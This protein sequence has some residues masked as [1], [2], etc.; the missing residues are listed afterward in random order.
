MGRDWVQIVQPLETA[1]QQMGIVFETAFTPESF[2]I[3]FEFRIQNGHIGRSQVRIHQVLPAG[4]ELLGEWEHAGIV[5]DN[6]DNT[7]FVSADLSTVLEEAPYEVPWADV[8]QMVW[9]F[10][11]ASYK[12]A[13]WTTRPE[14]KDRPLQPYG[15]G[16]AAAIARQIDQAKSVGIDGFIVSWRGPGSRSEQ[17]FP[18]ILQVAG[19][20]DFAI[21]VRLE[22]LTDA[23]Q[24]STPPE[25]AQRLIRLLQNHGRHSAFLDGDGRP[26]VFVADSTATPAATW[27]GIFNLVRTQGLDGFFLA[28]STN[29]SDADV[30]DALYTYTAT[31]AEEL[32]TLVAGVWG[33]PRYRH[34][35]SD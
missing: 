30:F 31:S 4:Q 19:Q 17:N 33:R 34:L 25:I 22:T 27:T 29:H 7:V 10:Y 23:G 8:P 11:E 15:S 24:P 18:A 21:S 26:V 16:V 1:G 12:Q 13:D 5:D 3:P 2:R 35:F 20:K 14:L 28:E 32:N 6:P 9:A